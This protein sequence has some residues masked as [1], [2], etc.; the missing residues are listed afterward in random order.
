MKLKEPIAKLRPNEKFIG[1][2]PKPC[3]KSKKVKK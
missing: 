2:K 1:L 3:R